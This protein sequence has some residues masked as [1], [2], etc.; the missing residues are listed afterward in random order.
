MIVAIHQPNYLP[1]LGY[2]AKLAQADLFVFLDDVQFSKNGYTNRVQVLNGSRR[3]WLTVPARVSLGDAINRVVPAKSDWA[4]SHCDTLSNFYRRAPAFRE[5]WPDIEAL[6]AN[7]PTDDIAAANIH[8]VLG[9]ARLLRLSR[10]TVR[11]STIDTGVATGDE[12]LAAIVSELAP[13]GTYLSGSG[14]RKYQDPATFD[15]RGIA[16]NYTRFAHP[17]YDQG[18]GFETGLSLVDAAFRLGWDATRDMIMASV[19]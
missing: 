6:Y 4:R 15:A 16:L 5:V 2:F 19:K 12:R 10:E 11:S 8:F 14:G 18:G 13:G 1:W 9:L 7:A 17:V 3:H